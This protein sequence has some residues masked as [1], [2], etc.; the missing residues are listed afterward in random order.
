MGYRRGLVKKDQS[1]RHHPTPRFLLPLSSPQWGGSGGGGGGC[2]AGA[3]PPA[4]ALQMRLPPHV[5]TGRDLCQQV[6]LER[7]SIYTRC[8]NEGTDLIFSDHQLI[9]VRDEGQVG[10]GEL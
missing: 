8:F 7:V 5:D 1:P 2:P 4:P 10:A 3:G 9:I 6:Q